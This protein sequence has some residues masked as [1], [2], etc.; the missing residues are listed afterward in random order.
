MT[1]VA[2]GWHTV[3]S[4]IGGEASGAVAWQFDGLPGFVLTRVIA[5]SLLT[6]MIPRKTSLK[7]SQKGKKEGGKARLAAVTQAS[8]H[9]I[10]VS[11]IIDGAPEEHS[12]RKS[13]STRE[14]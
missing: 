4:P 2:L 7:I 3:S 10:H 1:R 14:N 13:A 6:S 11:A 12:A 5:G 9:P 8:G